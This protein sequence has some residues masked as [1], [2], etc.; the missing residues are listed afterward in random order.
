MCCFIV[1][2]LS[3]ICFDDYLLLLQI[4]LHGNRAMAYLFVQPTTHVT[5]Q[6]FSCRCFFFAC[7]GSTLFFPNFFHAGRKRG[8]EKR[9]HL[10]RQAKIFLGQRSS[11][12]ERYSFAGDIRFD[13]TK[14]TPE[15]TTAVYPETSV[16]QQ[17]SKC[18]Q[19]RT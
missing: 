5:F 11:P 16:L 18:L 3:G 7:S 19:R 6:G 13:P 14:T 1:Y 4:F 12:L 15:S 17:S 10:H 2:V 9:E 8:L